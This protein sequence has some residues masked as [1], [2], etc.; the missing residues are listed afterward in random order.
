MEKNEGFVGV[1]ESE[2]IGRMKLAKRIN[3]GGSRLKKERKER[4]VLKG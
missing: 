4:G 1:E 2:R 3:N